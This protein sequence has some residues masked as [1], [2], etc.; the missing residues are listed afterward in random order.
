MVRSD[1]PG[2][3]RM[4]SH[5]NRFIKINIIYCSMFEKILIATD[6]S[7]HSQR[8]AKAGIDLAKLSGGKVTALHVVDL[9]RFLGDMSY[10]IADKVVEGTKSR[11]KSE[12]EAAIKQVEELAKSAGV[13]VEKKMAEG[14]PA[15]EILKAAASMDTVVIGSIGR[16]GMSKFLLGSVAEKVVRNSKVPVMVVY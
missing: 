13:P 16:R 12:G 14:H 15:D 6:G 9:D 1:I 5:S 7:P 3:Y 11:M 4:E 10:N 2:L 8:A